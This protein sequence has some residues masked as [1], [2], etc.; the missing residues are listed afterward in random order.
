MS[1][2]QGFRALKG[3]QDILPPAIFLWQQ[4]ESAARRIFTS[5][6][7]SEI[8]I[9]IFEATGV[10]VRSIGEDTDIVEKEMYTFPDKGG[11]SVTL[12]PEGTASV[13]RCYVQNNLKTLPSP[14]KFFYMGPMFRYERP[15]AGRLRQF[16]QIGVEAFGD[17]HPRMDAEVISMLARFLREIGLDGIRVQ[18]NSIGCDDCRPGYR[19][20]LLRYFA[21][22]LDGFCADCVRRF[23]RNPLRILD[24]KVP[25]CRE[26]RADAPKITDHLCGGCRGHFDELLNMLQKL[27]IAYEAVPHLV[28]GL[29]YYTRT[30]FEVT[31]AG[32]GAQNAVA[33]GGRYDQLVREFG[34]KDTPAT[35][36]AV[37]MERIAELLREGTSAVTPVPDAF[38][39][40]VGARASVEAL[41][42]AERLRAAGRWIEIG[43]EGG[44]LKSHL[45][46]AARLLSRY[47][48]ILGDDEIA[49]GRITW[50]R[51]SDA[52]QG[53]CPFDG[54]GNLLNAKDSSAD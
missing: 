3:V 46:R 19:E 15:Q 52:T 54:I 51:L 40:P 29:D 10:F 41:M 45:R 50:K 14:Q 43:E 37:G 17:P 12:R 23:E 2:E 9:P 53:E 44:S 16:Y 18:V 20:A 28:R 8:R 27:G 32:L 25:G 4:I 42:I 21:D 6:G 31:S 35:G 11:R 13:V 36:F 33:A 24:C 26:L 49:S 38:I 30:I 7:F 47:V 1:S 39:A 34:G 22:R 48:L 5:Y